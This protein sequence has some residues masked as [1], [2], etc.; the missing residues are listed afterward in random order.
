MS[1]HLF[2]SQAC[3]YELQS[4]ENHHRLMMCDENSWKCLTTGMTLLDL[5][6]QWW[7]KSRAA[8]LEHERFLT[9][10]GA[11]TPHRGPQHVP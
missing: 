11:W 2:K 1:V 8:I 7:P 6:G 3:S 10:H 9:F 5:E 4:L